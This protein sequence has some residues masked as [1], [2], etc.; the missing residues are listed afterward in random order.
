MN[1]TRH[2]MQHETLPQKIFYRSMIILF[3]IALLAFFLYVPPWI[4]QKLNHNAGKKHIRIFTFTDVISRDLVRDFEE[5]TG[6]Q[7]YLNYF[8][9]NEDLY[10]KLIVSKGAGYDLI[11]CSDYMTELLI[12]AKL[13]HTLDHEKI[14]HIQQVDTRLLGRYYDPRAQYSVPFGWTYY[15]IGLNMQYFRDKLPVPSWSSVFDRSSYV[16]SMPDDVRESVF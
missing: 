4:V 9:S 2:T 12:K 8:Q 5:K 14:S 3:W 15:G 7:V 11:V 16:V 13:L 6:I 1:K 10:A